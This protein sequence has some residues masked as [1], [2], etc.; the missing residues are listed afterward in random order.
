MQ[1]PADL[2]LRTITYQSSIDGL[3]PLFADC[4]YRPDGRPKP[5]TAVLHGFHCTR[6]HVTP[7]GIA[8]A[9]RGLFCVVPD[10]R[11]HGDSAG[12]HDCG[13]LQICDIVDAMGEGAAAFPGEVDR[14]HVNAVGY[15]GGGANVLS[16]ATKFPELL[17]A[18]ASFFGVS[19]YDIWY[20]TKGRTDCNRTMDRAIG[21]SPEQ[22]PDRYAARS[23][24][25]AVANNP[26]AD[27]RLFWDSEETSCPP[28]LN[29]WFVD[30]AQRLG[31]Q[32]VHACVSRPGDESRWHH[33]YRTDHPQ[34]AA[35]DAI[36]A[37]AFLAPPRP[38]GV[39]ARGVLDV[40]GYVV[41]TRFAVWLGDGKSGYAR[42]RY[43]LTGPAPVVECVD[44]AARPSL[45]VLPGP[46][47]LRWFVSP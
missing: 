23:S 46:T 21:G 3:G 38:W 29:E 42:I 30:A 37:P 19:D 11:G 18:G 10:M 16:L 24:L 34:L 6:G 25:R 8:L 43:D 44:G 7:D 2:V 4:I 26:H 31:R 36:F 47:C 15:S 1:I 5:L 13:A 17:S 40:C 33:G 20:R 12:E 41:T 39:P 27:L 9:R 14:Y 32:N 45:R 28:L 35:A 22:F